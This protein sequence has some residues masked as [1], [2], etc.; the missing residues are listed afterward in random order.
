MKL[1]TAATL[2]ALLALV[3][4]CNDNVGVNIPDA[5]QEPV[6]LRTIAHHDTIF[7][8]DVIEVTYDAPAG[9]NQFHSGSA[10]ASGDSVY[11]SV[12]HE[13]CPV[14]CN[15][16]PA[17]EIVELIDVSFD[18]AGVYRLVYDDVSGGRSSSSVTALAPSTIT[19]VSMSP[20]SPANL[21]Y[22]EMVQVTFDYWTPVPGGVRAWPIHVS[23]TCV[24]DT[25]ETGVGQGTTCFSM[26]NR[27]NAQ[28]VVDELIIRMASAEDTY[29]VATEVVIPVDYTFSNF[30][31][32]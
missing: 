24:S 16:E 28:E 1:R 25:Y 29:R 12:L 4:A 5:T 7:G 17:R 3:T 6:L 21:E 31:H 27:G 19:N 23:S 11:L 14:Y 30:A 22:G 18:A 8:P 13:T 26:A 20:P 15:D 32:R 2:T 9:R 10:V